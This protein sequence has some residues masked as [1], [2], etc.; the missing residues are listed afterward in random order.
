V[1]A[2]NI[3]VIRP[4]TDADAEALD[5]LA[6][7][8]SQP[9]LRGRILVGEVDGRP[10]AALSL[11]DDRAVAD[12]WQ[13]T[14]TLRVCLRLRASAMTAVETTPSLRERMLRAV[15]TAQPARPAA[16]PAQA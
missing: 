4:A 8:D 2:A 1:F 5:R 11:A 15:R 12:P 3:H 14:G 10:A 6:A 13:Y 9:P 7:L 16:A